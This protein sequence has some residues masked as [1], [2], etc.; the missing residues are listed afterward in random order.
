MA[1]TEDSESEGREVHGTISFGEDVQPFDRATAY[2]RLEDVSVA[3]APARVVAQSVISN[4]AKPRAGEG[5]PFTLPAGRINPR[6]SYNVRV[7]VDVDGDGQTTAGDY[8]S[9]QSYPVLT[10]G[11]P[12]EVSITVRR[13]R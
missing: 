9:V 11:Y 8:V 12:P 6:A 2:V 5:I 13:V 10:F 3:D 4:L 1:S 7:L